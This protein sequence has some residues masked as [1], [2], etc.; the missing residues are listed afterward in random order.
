MFIG[1]YVLLIWQTIISKEKSKNH[2]K[3]RLSRWKLPADTPIATAAKYPIIW[4]KLVS[5]SNDRIFLAKYQMLFVYLDI[6]VFIQYQSFFNY[7][8]IE[9]EGQ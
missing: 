5:S 3:H 6:D 8:F 2:F 7:S 4:P 1:Y 9:F